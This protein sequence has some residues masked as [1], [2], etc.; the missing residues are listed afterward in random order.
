MQLNA[1]FSQ[2][3]AVHAAD[4]GWTP[5]PTLGVERRMLDRIGGEVARA[6]SIVRYAPGVRFPSHVHGGGEELFVLEGVFSDEQGD[7]PAGT[8]VRN[9]PTSSHAPSSFHGC[10]IF[11]KL[12]QFALSDRTHVR[13]DTNK[14]GRVRVARRPGVS[15]SPLFRDDREDVRVEHWDS[16]ASLTMDVRGGLELFV[17]DGGFSEA[18]E[19]FGPQS[20]LRLP[21][22]P[23]AQLK[24]EDIGARV[25]VKS[26]HL[27][28][29]H[30]FEGRV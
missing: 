15:A 30:F 11:V 4:T 26:G 27:S 7:F 22:G 2:R 18:G 21:D 13:L 3:V 24:V 10:T 1:D 16:G 9:P 28:S 29:A 5:S 19:T 8:Y 23:P 14:M 20:W 25:L 12:W 6:T 17:L